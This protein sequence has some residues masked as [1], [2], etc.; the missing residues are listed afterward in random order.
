MG[1][2]LSVHKW[3]LLPALAVVGVILVTVAVG[4]EAVAGAVTFGAKVAVCLETGVL[5]G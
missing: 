3:L 2:V 4:K 1:T 5:A